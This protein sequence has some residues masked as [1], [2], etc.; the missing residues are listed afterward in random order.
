MALPERCMISLLHTIILD[1][2]NHPSNQ[3]L[4]HD[5]SQD[6]TEE[7]DRVEQGS[8]LVRCKSPCFALLTHGIKVNFSSIIWMAFR[9]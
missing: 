6:G 1:K 8:L 3:I 2:V 9:W 7:K 4:M 5:L